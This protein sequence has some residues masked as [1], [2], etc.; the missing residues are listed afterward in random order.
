MSGKNTTICKHDSADPG[1]TF[2]FDYSY[3]SHTNPSDDRFAGQRRVFEDMG[4]EALEHAIEG[5][6]VCVFAY[7]QTGSGKSYTMMGKPGDLEHEGLSPRLCRELF[8]RLE[9]LK[10]TKSNDFQFLVEVSY[11]EIYC[12]RVR[13]LLNSNQKGNLRVREHPLL[14]PYVED[15]SKCAVRSFE[16]VNDLMDAGNKSRTVAATN[17]NETSSRSHA[18]LTLLVTQRE[19]DGTTDTVGEKVSK[20]SLVD[21][22]GSERADATGAK[23]TRLKEGANINRSLTTL[24]K[25]IACLAEMATSRKK[26]NDFIPYRDSVLTWLLRENLGGNSQT[27]MLATLSP[28]DINYEETLST[29]RYADRAKQIVCKAV[30]NEDP[31][32]RM[33]RELKEEVKRLRDILRL[34]R[35]AGGVG[36]VT[37]LAPEM[38]KRPV[39][40]E[41]STE[42]REYEAKIEELRTSEKL[43]AELNETLETKLKRTESL[44]LHREQELREMGIALR[45]DGGLTG[46]FSPKT[47]NLVNLNEDPAMAECLIYYL[48]D[49]RTRLGHLHEAENLDIGLIGPFIRKEHC[50]FILENDTVFMEPI[51]DAECYVNGSRITQRQM[52]QPGARIILGKNHV[53]RLNNPLQ[54]RERRPPATDDMTVS[55]TE[56]VDWTYAIS[57]LLE[58]QGVDLRKEMDERLCQLEEQYRRE[59]AETEQR[60][61]QQRKAYEGQIQVL[62]EKVEQ[63][64]I[65]SS[66]VQD[67]SGSDDDERLA[68]MRQFVQFEEEF[69]KPPAAEAKLLTVS[70]VPE[71]RQSDSI[72][73][74]SSAVSCASVP[75]RGEDSDEE[76]QPND[77]FYDRLPWFQVIG[78]CYV[79][80]VNLFYGVSQEHELPLIDRNGER[81]GF[82]RV[83]IE[84][85]LDLKEEGEDKEQGSKGG[86]AS[87]VGKCPSPLF[88]P[89]SEGCQ[90]SGQSTLVFK[91]ADYFRQVCSNGR[92]N[93]GRLAFGSP[94]LLPTS[95]T[96]PHTVRPERQNTLVETDESN[97]PRA[98]H[99]RFFPADSTTSDMEP[100]FEKYRYDAPWLVDD[101]LPVHLRLGSQFRFRVTI[102]E[103]YGICNAFDDIFCQFFFENKLTEVYSTEPLPNKQANSR[104]EFCQV[105]CFTVPVTFAFIDYIMRRTLA[106]EVFGHAQC[107]KNLNA[108]HSTSITASSYSLR[109][110]LPPTLLLSPPVPSRHADYTN[111]KADGILLH[112]SDLLVWFEILELSDAG[113]YVPVPVLRS[114]ETSG[115]GAFLLHQGL[116]RRIAVTIVQHPEVSGGEDG[117]LAP[118]A[119]FTDVREVVVGRAR[120]TPE[121]LLSDAQTQILSLSLLSARYIPQAGDDRTFFRFEAAWDSSLHGSYLLN[122]ATPKGQRVYITMSCYVELEG[123]IRPACL[124]KDLPMII[125]PRSSKF[126]VPS[127]VKFECVA[128]TRRMSRNLRARVISPHRCSVFGH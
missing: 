34:E 77:P 94:S 76:F 9:A 45:R 111:R 17:M 123:A 43:L 52:V 35:S 7:G 92:W 109:R 55:L 64:S 26:K 71:M 48:K 68:E 20:I 21:L 28:A 82:I 112:Q 70:S 44:R 58:K 100:V 10:R 31:N 33:I 53:F 101:E 19:T 38:I 124:T 128:G 63:Q 62:Q 42:L 81:T 16:E 104:I 119:I 32:A 12:E 46:V 105:Q 39:D 78:R 93:D 80:L 40:M 125:F 107:H 126:T 37:S 121:F 18:V 5:Y 84:P 51:G 57:E 23:G 4:V 74:G 96:T 118:P 1:K 102:L 69:S 99:R 41:T 65:M 115:Q 75:S 13:D 29:L 22:A 122:R 25:V 66:I 88:S 95:V 6:N 114:E 73:G 50:E 83:L 89:N 67:D 116:Q 54:R 87:V 60:F 108:G 49:G 27:M 36:E 117:L 113:E 3:W 2:Q 61:D 59:R 56:P 97:T 79:Y 91:D 103:V 15:L 98:Q 86:S 106:F 24:G 127:L 85:V 11:M 120:D 47:P 30:I 8:Q 72:G 110:C 14:G 90:R